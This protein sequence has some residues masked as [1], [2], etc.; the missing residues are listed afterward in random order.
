M[1]L[2][3]GRLQLPEFVGEPWF[4]VVI[5]VTKPDVKTLQL[6]QSK[7]PCSSRFDSAVHLFI[8]ITTWALLVSASA[9]R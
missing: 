5:V 3:L 6:V 9:C 8:L 1:G 4:V 2:L 7:Q